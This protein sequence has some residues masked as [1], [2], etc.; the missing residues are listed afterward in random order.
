MTDGLV[1]E[2]FQEERVCGGFYLELHVYVIPGSPVPCS[3][4]FPSLV[5]SEILFE[6]GREKPDFFIRQ[7]NFL[8]LL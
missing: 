3:H 1:V 7:I 6:S 8:D 2:A 5:R 4:S